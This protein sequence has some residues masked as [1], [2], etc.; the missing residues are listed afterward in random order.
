MILN[1]RQIKSV[2]RGVESVERKKGV[3][4]FNRF[5]KKELNYYNKTE[6]KEKS[7]S[8]SCVVMEFK[9]DGDF[10]DFK[11]NAVY[12][13]TRTYFAFDIFVDNEFFDC[14]NNY[15]EEELKGINYKILKFEIGTYSKRVNL[16]QGEKRIKVIF[17]WSV[18]TELVSFEVGNA[19]YITP[20]KKG[21]KVV[22]YGDSI[23]HG[24][25][26]LH[27]S[28]AYAMRFSSRFDMEVINKAIG[29]E[30]YV[31]NL[32]VKEKITM[33]N[34]LFVA[35]GSNDWKHSSKE[36]FS[37]DCIEFYKK[38]AVKYPNV[39]TIVITPIYRVDYSL[40]TAFDSFLEV[41]N[42]IKEVCSNYNNITVVSGWEFNLHDKSYFV[43][44]LHPKGSAFEIYFNDLISKIDNIIEK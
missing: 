17:P 31:P 23:T 37:N 19:T 35:Y 22:F 8:T 29:G 38:L 1:L 40:K 9:T 26:T 7:L 41:E 36:K 4:I 25:D 33:P 5:T 13:T 12:G 39:K 21:K 3:I 11:V 10:I 24:Y 15:N 42:I 43:D 16:K 18:K 2:T 28:N 27:P 20:I 32:L 34:Y 14:L 30:V 44:G 6:Y